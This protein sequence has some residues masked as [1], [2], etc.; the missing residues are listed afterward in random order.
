[1]W[2]SFGVN[3]SDCTFFK[4]LHNIA[5]IINVDWFKPFKRSEYKIGRIYMNVLN[6]PRTDRYKRKWTML[7]GLIPGP[8]EP[9]Q[10]IN[11]FLKPLV[12]DLIELWNGV[13]LDSDT[14]RV[15]K[16]ALIAVSCDIPAA[17]KVCQFLGHKANKG[18]SRCEFE[19]QQENP[20]VATS[21]M[22]YYTT[23]EAVPRQ[24][25]EFLKKL[26]LNKYKRKMESDGVN[27]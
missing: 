19:A 13:P 10:S 22:S 1:M 8:S 16:G 11:S 23:E 7:I 26:K 4:D 15:I 9:K 21:R 14:G 24:A 2:Q 18:C 5:L 20:H 6:L 17:R 3:N 27:Y 12:D 25:E